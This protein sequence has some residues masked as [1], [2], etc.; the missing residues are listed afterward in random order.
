MVDARPLVSFAGCPIFLRKFMLSRLSLPTLMVLLACMLLT[1]LLPFLAASLSASHDPKSNPQ[2][3]LA[4]PAQAAWTEQ[5]AHAKWHEDSAAHQSI[6]G[7]P[8]GHSAGDHTHHPLFAAP[9]DQRLR[10][11]AGLP[12][13]S[14]SDFLIGPGVPV[15]MLERPPRPTPA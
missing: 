12:E 3:Q 10:F 4:H 5:D 6:W 13:W 14:L 1:A 7:Q 9:F 11:A 2:A 8:L 15:G